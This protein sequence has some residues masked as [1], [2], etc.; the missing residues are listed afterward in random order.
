MQRRAA[1]HR[2]AG[3][4]GVRNPQVAG[5]ELRVAGSEWRAASSGGAA[6]TTGAGRIES[7]TSQE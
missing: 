3:C 4:G 5:H 7:E 1:R 6:G 2:S